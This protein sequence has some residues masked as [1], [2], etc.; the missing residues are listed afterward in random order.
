MRT[1]EGHKKD[2]KHVCVCVHMQTCVV[3]Q[4]CL[5]QSVQCTKVAEEEK[6]RH[7]IEGG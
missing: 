4:M 3:E 5:Q 7:R 2:H 1:V 6:G